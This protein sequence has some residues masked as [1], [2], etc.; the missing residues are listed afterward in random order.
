MP[1]GFPKAREPG[2]ETE[3][4]DGGVPRASLRFS[5]PK[6]HAMGHAFGDNFHDIRTY[7]APQ[8][9]LSCHTQTAKSTSVMSPLEMLLSSCRPPLIHIAPVLDLLGI[10]SDEHLHAVARMSEETRDREVKDEALRMGVTVVE[11]AIL[12]DRLVSC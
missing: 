3:S 4:S 6:I 7:R 8:S 2:T 5:A 10:K 11:W 1:N 9:A 12:V